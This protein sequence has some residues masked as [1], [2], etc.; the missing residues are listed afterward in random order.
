VG[1]DKAREYVEAGAAALMYD[2]DGRPVQRN[3][4]HVEDLVSAILIALDH[5]A[6]RQQ[7]LHIAMDEPVDYGAL[8]DYLATT[9][10][11]PSIDIASVFHSTW[12]DNRKARLDLGWRPDYNLP[13]LVEAAWDYRRAPDDPR[14]IWYP[15]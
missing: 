6:A 13:R 15:G 4:V 14:R 9:R 5:P 7:T 3:F 10:G 1:P 8:A 11:L 12:L 2:A